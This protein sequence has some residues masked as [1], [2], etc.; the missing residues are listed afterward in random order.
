[1]P[2][3]LN[4]RSPTSKSLGSFVRMADSLGLTGFAT[5]LQRDKPFETLEG[6]MDLFARIDLP[7]S[8]LRA[9][10]KAA[11]EARPRAAVLAVPLRGVDVSNWAAEDERVDFLTIDKPHN[12][13]ILRESTAKLAAVSGT[14][15]EVPI[16]PLLTSFGLTRSKVIKVFRE[17][18][19]TAV[20]M[21]M[22]VILS[23]GSKT[24]MSMRSPTAMRYVGLLLGLDWKY[25]KIAVQEGPQSIIDRSK[26]RLG[27][28]FVAPGVEIVQR[29]ETE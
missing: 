2:I 4:V 1:M 16:E 18:V 12:E 14:A 22:Q 9:A 21:G 10:K 28:D 17:N 20:G 3:D 8:G 27:S 7:E 6:G 23:S 26:K 11:K 19:Q 24:V 5:V 25:T 13:C 15:L 29:G